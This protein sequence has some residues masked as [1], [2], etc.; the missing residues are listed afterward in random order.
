MVSG[1]TIGGAVD[2]GGHGW[3]KGGLSTPA[4]HPVDT[5]VGS[6]PGWVGGRRDGGDGRFSDL[7]TGRG[8][9]A[10]EDRKRRQAT[11]GMVSGARARPARG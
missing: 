6:P 3:T 7:S 9:G 4:Y 5:P 8:R 10:E 1:T 11:P 2:T